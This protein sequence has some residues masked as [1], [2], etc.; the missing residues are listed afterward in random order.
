MADCLFM[1][2]DMAGAMHIAWS[3]QSNADLAAVAV[4]LSRI[5]ADRLIED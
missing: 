3:R 4:V 1:Y 5:A 2:T